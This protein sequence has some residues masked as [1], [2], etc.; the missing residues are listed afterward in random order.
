MWTS[1]QEKVFSLPVSP[2][3]P[4]A[5]VSTESL[6][7]LP[8]H[9]DFNSMDKTKVASLKAPSPPTEP[10]EPRMPRQMFS[11]SPL[12]AAQTPLSSMDF[13]AA[14]CSPLILF[15]PP[16]HSAPLCS[17]YFLLLIILPTA[18][19]PPFKSFS[20]LLLLLP[21]GPSSPYWSLSPLLIHLLPPVSLA[22][23]CSCSILVVQQKF[24]DCT[25][26]Y[27]FSNTS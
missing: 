1:P 9:I 13:S 18:P 22:P 20:F 5:R 26:F 4:E 21:P 11:P 2:S 15:F 8:A 25:T 14:W 6:K 23:S 7:A 10:V 12:S 19:S 27:S 17:F 24:D 16:N 3:P